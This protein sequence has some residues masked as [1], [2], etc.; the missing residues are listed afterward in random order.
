MGRKVCP[1]LPLTTPGFKAI[2]WT[3]KSQISVYSRE[4]DLLENLDIVH[5]TLL[6]DGVLGSKKLCIWGAKFRERIKSEHVPVFESRANAHTY[7][8]G[9]HHETCGWSY[10]ALLGR[11]GGGALRAQSSYILS[12]RNLYSARALQPAPSTAGGCFVAVIDQSMY[13]HPLREHTLM[14]G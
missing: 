11:E 5:I 9:P 14:G 13:S 8:D 12:N 1:T 6:V 2:R 3:L 10:A 7:L 4:I